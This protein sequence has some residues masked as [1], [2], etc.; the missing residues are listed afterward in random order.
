MG[1]ERFALHVLKT[2]PGP[3]AEPVMMLIPEES[4][5]GARFWKP[6]LCH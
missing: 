1:A 2:G 4:N 6:P 5:L 3:G